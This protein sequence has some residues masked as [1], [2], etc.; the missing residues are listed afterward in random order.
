MRIMLPILVTPTYLDVTLTVI[1][2]FSF[3]VL[4]YFFY[5][6]I[7]QPALKVLADTNSPPPQ[8]GEKR[9]LTFKD[10]RQIRFRIGLFDSDWKLRMKGI[11]EDHLILNFKKDRS[12]EE[13][14]IDLIPGGAVFYRPP[15]EQQ[16]VRMKNRERIESRELIGHPAILRLVAALQ[17]E[18]QVVFISIILVMN[19]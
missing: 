14:E 10:T 6:Y 1:G 3:F 9:E 5:R 17:G 15:H 7:L 19:E 18:R 12:L 11:V 2:L 4:F 8:Q 13:Y 16:L